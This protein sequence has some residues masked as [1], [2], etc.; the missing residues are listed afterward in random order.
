M[1]IL[2]TFD[3]STNKDLFKKTLQKLFDNTDRDAISEWKQVV[4]P[5]KA[6]DLY[7][8]RMRIAGLT[9]PAQVTEGSPITIQEPKYG[10]TK[11]WTQI[12]F[13]T[14]FKVSWE[15]KKF[16]KWNL[17]E[18]WTRNLKQVMETYKN[19]VVFRLFNYADATTYS[20]GYDTLALAHDSH[21]C[22]DDSSSTYDNKTTSALSVASLETGYIYFR[23]L[24][25]DQAQTIQKKPDTLLV[26]PQLE[27]TAN[28]LVKANMVPFEMSN[29][30]NEIKRLGLKVIVASY[31]TDSNNW[32]LLCHGDEDYG[33]F[34]A[35]SQEA[36][37]DTHD[38][39]DDTRSTVVTSMM[40]FKQGFDDARLTY[41]GI[42][43]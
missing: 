29:T 2:T 24:K 31:L 15:V 27:F 30:P 7:E 42:V 33:L 9:G 20:A 1:A 32:F 22:L 4:K 6:T 10:S 8:R 5:I 11:E 25:D 34:C 39:Y 17:V 36:D 21:T 16:N 14:G 23:T 40:A 35:T 26:P 41:A 38:A 19:Q 43:T 12:K 18:K 28:Q 13:G 37:L 3:A